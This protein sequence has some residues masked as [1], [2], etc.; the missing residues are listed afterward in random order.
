[1][2]KQRTFLGERSRRFSRNLRGRGFKPT[3]SLN[4]L[5]LKAL[6][7]LTNVNINFTAKKRKASETDSKKNKQK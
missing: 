3:P 5:M 7:T 4:D 6:E 2:E 1:M